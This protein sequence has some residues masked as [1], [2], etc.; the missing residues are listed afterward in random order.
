GGA[1]TLG[2]LTGAS[3][4]GALASGLSLT[5]RKSAVGLTRMVQI[6][7][8]TLGSALIFF[9][10][11]H[12]L[13]LSLLLMVFVGFGLM[14][15]AA[16]SNTIIQSLVPEDKRGRAMSYYTMAFFGGA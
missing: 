14:Q 2:W 1:H 16:A 8:A 9:G 5:L 4:V 7:S 12:T 10:L 3:G 15:T 6:A 13:W 11:S